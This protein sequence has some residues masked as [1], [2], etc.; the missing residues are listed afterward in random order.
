[1]SQ[2][3]YTPW[4]EEVSE[5]IWNKR[6][7]FLDDKSVICKYK[8]ISEQWAEYYTL[9]NDEDPV[10]EKE[11]VDIRLLTGKWPTPPPTNIKDMLD[12]TL[13]MSTFCSALVAKAN[14][15]LKGSETGWI[16]IPPGSNNKIYDCKIEDAKLRDTVNKYNL[17]NSIYD[18]VNAKLQLWTDLEDLSTTRIISSTDVN[19]SEQLVTSL[20]DII[21]L[22]DEAPEIIVTQM[23]SLAG[24]IAAGLSGNYSS[25][26]QETGSRQYF[27]QWDYDST[28]DYLS[29]I[30]W[31]SAV[32]TKYQTWKFT[33]L[34]G[35]S[36]SRKDATVNFS[37][38]KRQYVLNTIGDM[39]APRTDEEREKA[40]KTKEEMEKDGKG[41]F[42]GDF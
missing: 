31:H 21:G 38:Y 22:A 28:L 19:V 25:E 2:K 36:V 6:I 8:W 41:I 10:S 7:D 13:G 16:A 30:G 42:E 3:Y 15:K 23:K 27:V 37:V 39:W 18:I 11:S 24:T 5:E 33:G 32:H 12:S 26:T 14:I 20:L 40:R 4:G 1:M 17:E 35:S 9:V 34:C 29:A